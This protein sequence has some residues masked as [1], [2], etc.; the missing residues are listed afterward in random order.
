MQLPLLIGIIQL[1]IAA[2]ELISKVLDLF[3]DHGHDVETL[4]TYLGP[5]IDKQKTD[6][7]N[8]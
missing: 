1:L 3:H 8:L 6:I 2:P 4:R 7:E 5:A